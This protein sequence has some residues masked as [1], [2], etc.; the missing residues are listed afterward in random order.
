[1]PR[2]ESVEK[3]QERYAGLKARLQEIGLI[4][5]GSI[6]RRTIRREDPREPGQMKDYGPYHQWTRKAAGRTVIQNLAGGQAKTYGAAI[7][8]HRRLEQ[9]LSQMRV[10]SLKLLELTTEGVP[11]RAPRN[12]GRK[13]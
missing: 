1:M 6:L 13:P 11:R 12:A 2:K 5:Q 9:I 10:V 3:L 8:E 7:R 4:A